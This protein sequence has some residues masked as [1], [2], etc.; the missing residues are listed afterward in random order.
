M[1]FFIKCV[2]NVKLQYFNII[3][4]S[5]KIA[6]PR[7]EKTLAICNT[8]DS[9]TTTSLNCILI[10]YLSPKY[11]IKLCEKLNSSSNFKTF[12]GDLPIIT[13]VIY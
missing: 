2:H 1:P 8:M 10:K 9:F 13:C 5:H 6:T 4:K 12:S 3:C 11:F 7:L